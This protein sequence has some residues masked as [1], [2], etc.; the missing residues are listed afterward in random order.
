MSLDYTDVAIQLVKIRQFV[1][2]YVIRIRG[3]HLQEHY[4]K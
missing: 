1:E 2:I 3:Y 4:E